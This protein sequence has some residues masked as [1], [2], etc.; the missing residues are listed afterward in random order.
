M[1]LLKIFVVIAFVIINWCVLV[2][3]P[4]VHSPFVLE[5]TGFKVTKSYQEPKKSEN[6]NIL[7]LGEVKNEQKVVETAV[8]EAGSE[9]LQREV[10]IEPSKFYQY[11]NGM[12]TKETSGTQEKL[13]SN[14]IRQ[15]V[16]S[17]QISEPAKPKKLTKREE[18]IAWNKWRSDLQNK[19]MIDSSVEA[20]F[21]T[22]ITYSFRVS[23]S[24]TISNIKVNCTNLAYTT[25]VREAL[26][27]LIKSYSGQDIL[28]FP[29]GSERKFIDFKGAFLIWF[30]T[31]YSSPDDFSD[32]ERVQRY[33]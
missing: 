25:K 6:I 22:L 27:P 4:S 26:I 18:T 13:V 1:T 24:R 19:V 8:T 5:E 21:G 29:E 15:T 11:A 20:P 2:F 32:F 23:R 30:E 9:N 3:S 28:T 33:E 12:R 14:N 10:H 16:T 31:S 17:G 7:R